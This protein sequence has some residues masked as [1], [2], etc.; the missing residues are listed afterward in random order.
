MIDD[1]GNERAACRGEPA[2]G[3]EGEADEQQDIPRSTGPAT[4]ITG[5]VI[6]REF[7]GS[8]ETISRHVA[9]TQALAVFELFRQSQTMRYMVLAGYMH[10]KNGGVYG[11]LATGW[12]QAKKLFA[13]CGIRLDEL[14]DERGSDFASK[15][16]IFADDA[17]RDEILS[18]A[19]QAMGWQGTA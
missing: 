3:P 8:A 14:A 19:A 12:D 15:W 5:C 2:D 6:D 1:P 17:H 9:S 4:F 7:S 18:M 11:G 10:S 13:M 16:F